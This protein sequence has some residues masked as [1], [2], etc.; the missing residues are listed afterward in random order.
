MFHTLVFS[1]GAHLAAVFIGCVRYLEHTGLRQAVRRV[2]GSSAGALT[3][4][5]FALGLSGEEIRR[6]SFELSSTHRINELSVDNALD[7]CETLGIDPGDNLSRAVRATL[8]RHGFADNP[9]PSFKD[10]A[11]ATGMDLCV[12]VL[13]LTEMHFEYLSLDTTPRMSVT[14]ALRMSMSVPLI[15]TPVRSKGCL[16]IDP[17][18]GRNF[19]YD[20]PGRSAATDA[21][22]LG[23]SVRTAV[24]DGGDGG[25]AQHG[26]DAQQHA[27]TVD[28][29]SYV[30]SLLSM[31]MRMSNANCI[32]E[33]T[34]AFTMIHVDVDPAVSGRGLHAEPP[35]FKWS[36]AAVAAMSRIGYAAA[37]QVIGLQVGLPLPPCPGPDSV[38]NGP[39][40]NERLERAE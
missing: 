35:G 4:L 26:G 3:A 33:A 27:D 34:A 15:F 5:L 16:Y 23:V 31:M 18:I 12:C 10:L 11:Q 14:T 19:P 8:D 30:A 36:P 40:A 1:G 13:N 22:V 20:F 9:D 21:G 2:V 28:I 6:W 38:L 29:V 24:Q 25:D 39:D 17:L 37:Q 7:I 32:G